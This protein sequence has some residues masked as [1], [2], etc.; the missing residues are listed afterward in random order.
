[1]D[2]KLQP[3]IHADVSDLL[4]N[5]TAHIHDLINLYGSPLHII[6]P[7]IMLHNTH[8][9]RQIF[10]DS[11]MD[12]G[13][14][15]FPA[16]A[17]KANAFL[18]TTAYM[19]EGADV[20]SMQEFG[21]ALKLGVRSDAISVS[22]P[23]KSPGLMTLAIQHGAIIAID[24][25]SEL[26][27]INHIR[28]QLNL[29]IPTRICVRLS[30][31]ETSR[32]GIHVNELAAMLQQIVI[33]QPD[34]VLEGFSFHCNG[35]ATTDRVRMIQQSCQAITTAYSLGLRPYRINIGGGF[36]VTYADPDDWS[37]D[38]ATAREFADGIAPSFVYPYAPP[39]ASA[40]QL[41]KILTTARPTIQSLS[42]KQQ[43]IVVDAEPGR[44]LLDQAGIT[45]FRIR[46][47]R[48]LNKRW[49]V[50]VDGNIYH[51]SES[52]FQ[53]E[54]LIDPILISSGKQHKELF[55]AAIAGNTCLEND[56]LARR[57]VP[58]ASRPK[59]NDLLIYVNTAGYQMDSNESE[60][61]RLPLPHKV[62][63]SKQSHRWNFVDDARFELSD[64][65]K[66]L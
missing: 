41:K 6:F 28:T 58:F 31:A 19:G 34:V 53:S 27:L 29:S 46:S 65:L 40:T 63:A 26:R 16:K 48:S 2:Y 44:A 25:I 43:P 59:V 10:H 20:S 60:F 4:L 38:H 47:I 21:A 64:M 22:G 13:K 45:I 52:W 12:A 5:N 50:G 8:R 32:F 3:K 30:T 24:E 15:Y 33:L 55:T 37:L 49:V 54:F 17:N 62:I 61:H 56:Y 39:D 14:L 7:D 23:S 42:T 11:G 57:F 9:F 35:Y 51:L 1:M 66:R 36:A 18:A